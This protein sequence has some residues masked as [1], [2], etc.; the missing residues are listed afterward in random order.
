MKNVEMELSDGVHEL[1]LK[2]KKKNGFELDSGAMYHL[3]KELRYTE[4]EILEIVRCSVES[5][6]DASKV[7]SEEDMSEKMPFFYLLL[8]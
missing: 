8:M 4:N 7:L 5:I 2:Y 3:L 1:W 6:V